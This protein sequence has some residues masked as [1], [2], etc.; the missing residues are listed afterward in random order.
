[1][2]TIPK[3][4]AF[5]LDTVPVRSYELIPLHFFTDYQWLMDFSLCTCVVYALNEFVYGV[6][7]GGSYS[8]LNLSLLW[9]L[10]AFFFALRVLGMLA[11]M[12]FK[13]GLAQNAESGEAMLILT[14]GFFFLV[15]AMAVLILPSSS[16]Q[17][18]LD[19]AYANFSSAARLFLASEKGSHDGPINL[20]SVRAVLAFAAAL[21]A[22][23]LT[24]P[25]LR[26][27]KMYVDALRYCGDAAEGA[28]V[29]SLSALLRKAALH[30]SFFAPVLCLLLWLTPVTRELRA[31][32]ANQV[33]SLRLLL[34]LATCLLRLLLAPQHLQA[35]LN[36]AHERTVALR[37]EAGRVS[38]VE[39]QKGVARI[40]YYLCVVALQYLCPILL[41]LTV[42]CLL[43][44]LGGH[45]WDPEL[46][47]D[48]LP[49]FFKLSVPAAVP[50][51]PLTNITGV[52]EVLVRLFGLESDLFGLEES[53]REWSVSVFT[54]LVYRCLLGFLLF[55]VLLVM[56]L[57][58]LF[59]L[60]YHTYMT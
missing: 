19:A 33:A 26:F 46:I 37:K 11:K 36:L 47:Y 43:K 14:S 22:A 28:E 29:F 4:T 27:A 12:Y 35:Y 18:D 17:L 51:T 48:R 25:G 32:S 10:L 49:A 38:N 21:L 24:F 42:C 53:V 56:S 3:T 54:P 41:L 59:G 9:C 23:L 5:A 39:L 7:Y 30:L 44:S 6:L 31:L 50:E 16:L 40:F 1:M 15:V 20:L 55:W 13:S 57:T 8:R 34:V 58:S 60:L 52:P 45:S 2:F